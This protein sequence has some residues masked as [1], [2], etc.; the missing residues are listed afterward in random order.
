MSESPSYSPRHNLS[1][2][3]TGSVTVCVLLAV[4]GLVLLCLGLTLLTNDSWA[5][6]VEFGLVSAFRYWLNAD[7][8]TVTADWVFVALGLI[9]LIWSLWRSASYLYRVAA[10]H[11]NTSMMSLAWRRESRHDFKIVVLGGGTGLSTLLRGLKKHSANLTAVVSVSDNGGSSGRLSKEFH[12]LPPGDIR[13]C[14]TALA[15]NEDLLTQLLCYRFESDSDKEQGLH[16]HSFGNLFIAALYRI[17]H[18]DF[19]VALQE[20]SDLLAIRGR[21]LPA[22]LT[23][24]VLCA[25]M[26]DQRIIKGETEIPEAHG[27]ITDVFLEIKESKDSKDGTTPTE[28]EAPDAV[29]KAI[30]EADGIILGPGSLYTSVMPNLL[31]KNIRK[32]LEQTSAPIIYVCNVMTQSGETDGYTAADH[33]QA[34]IHHVKKNIVSYVIANSGRPSEELCQKYASEGSVPV[35][36]DYDRLVSMGVKPVCA[37]LFRQDQVVRH[38]PDILADTIFNLLEKI[39]HSDGEHGADNT[40]SPRHT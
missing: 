4:L 18:N 21:V 26:R 38:D 37:K 16:G 24:T 8:S 12:M 7:I 9:C 10:A 11:P 14:L 28:C 22:T 15:D 27:E 19:Q 5:M 34:L 1:Q 2:P 13:N 3:T 33:L 20:V 30:A 17:C 23:P 40:R 32:A 31:I 36:L 29:L 25:K 39:K 35:E 6:R